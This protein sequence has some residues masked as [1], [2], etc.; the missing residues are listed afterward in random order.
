[1]ARALP[2]RWEFRRAIEA[3]GLA[4]PD[5]A[6]ID[7]LYDEIDYDGDGTLTIEEIHFFLRT[8]RHRK[9]HRK[10]GRKVPRLANEGTGAPAADELGA[11]PCRPRLEGL[12]EGL[13]SLPLRGL[14][15]TSA[16]AQSGRNAKALPARRGAVE[17]SRSLPMLRPPKQQPSRPMLRTSASYA[18]V[19]LPRGF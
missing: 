17:G 6:I 10:N 5:V 16:S 8:G 13:P 11:A 4:V 1:M 14:E 2:R 19:G 15:D 3:M 18:T 12:L 9:S 7:E